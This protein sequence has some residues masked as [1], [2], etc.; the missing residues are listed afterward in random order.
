MEIAWLNHVTTF[1]FISN[2]I[3]KNVQ[4]IK[5]LIIS[6]FMDLNMKHVGR[7]WSMQNGKVCIGILFL[8]T[9]HVRNNI[10][11]YINHRDI[12]KC[13]SRNRYFC[14]WRLLMAFISQIPNHTCDVG[15]TTYDSGPNVGKAPSLNGFLFVWA[16]KM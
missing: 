2:S 14:I 15:A 4:N 6:M 13:F 7:S 9:F 5:L 10:Y 3:H 11:I 1:M 16:V 12:W 8:Q